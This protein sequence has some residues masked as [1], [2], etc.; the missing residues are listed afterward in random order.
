M[1]QFS[2]ANPSKIDKYFSS[3]VCPNTCI[4]INLQISFKIVV[5]RLWRYFWF[6]FFHEVEWGVTRSK[7]QSKYYDLFQLYLKSVFCLLYSGTF[8]W[9]QHRRYQVKNVSINRSVLNKLAATVDVNMHLLLELTTNRKI[10]L[11]FWWNCFEL[12]GDFEIH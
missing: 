10:S 3:F 5:Q 1:Q 4:T 9:L 2:A 12:F 11:N 6:R 7:L 8:S